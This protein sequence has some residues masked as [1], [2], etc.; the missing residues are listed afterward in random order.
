MQ[1]ALIIIF[2]VMALVV[3]LAIVAFVGLLIVFMEPPHSLRP[4]WTSRAKDQ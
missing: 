2:C 1:T 3:F 4:R